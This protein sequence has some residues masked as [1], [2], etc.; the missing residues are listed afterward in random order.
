[1]TSPNPDNSG[2]TDE[3]LALVHEGWNHLRLQRPIASWACWQ[4][5]LRIQPGQ[6]AA[7]EALAVLENAEELP[8]SARLPLRFRSP[9]SAERR[10]EWSRAFLGRDLRELEEAADVFASLL[11][12]DDDDSAAS[13]NLGLCWAWRGRND[14]AISFFDRSVRVD[15]GPRHQEAIDSWMLAEILRQGA[16]AEELCDDLSHSLTLEWLPEWGDFLRDI[17]EFASLRILNIPKESVVEAGGSRTLAIA[18]WLDRPLSTEGRAVFSYVL[19]TI[20]VQEGSVRLTS[21]EL[22]RLE[23]AESALITALGDRFRPLDRRST[24]LPLRF[25]DAS[26]WSFRIPDLEDDGEASDLRRSA[27]EESYEHLWI[28]RPRI[29]LAD[30][31]AGLPITPVDASRGDAVSRA[32]LAAVINIREQLAAR[33][34]M[35]AI[36]D[37]YPFDRLRRRLGL[38]MNDES[39]V[40]P[41]DVTCMSRDELGGLDLTSLSAEVFSEAIVAAQAICDTTT[42]GR[43]ALERATRRDKSKES[44]L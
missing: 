19:A 26:A 8:I 9:Q 38:P 23:L 40:E 35:K 13:Y 36:V 6:P 5:A 12:R 42:L 2:D 29:G 10:E 21:P 44:N 37:G 7:T 1:M 28:L 39:T 15:A 43:F 24:P 20:V 41:T 22:E 18:E 33:P 11:E 34:R 14:L 25:M 27:I 16:G 31:P 30:E 3:V 17:V 32:K 4:R